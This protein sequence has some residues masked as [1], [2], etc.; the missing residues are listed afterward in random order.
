MLNL[1]IWTSSSAIVPKP[2]VLKTPTAST[3]CALWI[4]GVL[5]YDWPVD[6]KYVLIPMSDQSHRSAGTKYGG[7]FKTRERCPP[8]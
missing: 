1:G 8:I 6:D 4:D 3:V 2:K 7:P 5:C